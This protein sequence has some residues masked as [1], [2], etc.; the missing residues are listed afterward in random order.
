MFK[1]TITLVSAICLSSTT[2]F[3]NIGADQAR[4]VLTSFDP[5]IEQ[6]IQDFNIPG[7]AIGVIVDGEVVYSKGFGLRNVDEQL[8]V[9][10]DT[11]FA[12][13]S[14][15]KAFTSFVASS[16]VEEGKLSWDKPILDVLPQFRLSND[17]ATSHITLRDLLAHRS[18]MARH[19][20][21]YYNSHFTRFD[22]MQKLRYLE[23]AWDVR[24][25]FSYGD[26]MYLPVGFA[27]EAVTGK[28]WEELV[29]EKVLVPLGMTHTNFSI[30]DSKNS[31]DFATPYIEKNGTLKAMALRNFSN[32]GPAASMNSSV[33]DM[34]KW[35]KMLLDGGSHEAKSLLSTG[36]L[37][38][39]FGSQIIA[40]S[41][42]ENPDVLLSAYGIGWYVHPYRGLYSVSHDGGLDGFV[43]VVSLFPN[44]RTGVVVLANKNLNSLPRYLSMEIVDRLHDLPSRNWIQIATDSIQTAQKSAQE[45]VQFEDSQRKSGTTLSHPME[46]YVGSYEHP[47]YGVMDIEIADGYLLATLNGIQSRLEHW[48]YDVFSLDE[49]LQDLLVSRKGLKFAFRSNAN[50]AISEI[51]VP[52][53]QKTDDIVFTKKLSSKFSNPAY[54]KPYIGPYEIYGVSVDIVLRNGGLIAMIPGQSDYELEPIAENEFNVKNDNYLVR[55]VMGEDGL[56]SEVLLVLPFGAYSAERVRS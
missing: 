47:A 14:C 38:E 23:P 31:Y 28:T 42:T 43:S 8:P 24:E 53:E 39:M 30:E 5:I 16:L 6:T 41:Y 48:H 22:L 35:M 2:L 49:D 1:K 21:L 44:T 34:L 18:G 17:H 55:F 12:L 36:Y 46:D 7:L 3:A 33:S 19:P 15:T 25:R 11:I 52:L 10:T 37:Q 56:A 54:F 26:L 51:T 32:I 13:A 4:D 9:T 27:M 40:S 50:G 29:N 20:Y 45:N